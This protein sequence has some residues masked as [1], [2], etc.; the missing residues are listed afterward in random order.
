MDETMDKTLLIN[1][2][3]HHAVNDQTK[4]NQTVK[5]L[6]DGNK[7]TKIQAIEADIIYSSIQKCSVMG[8]PPS[9]DG[10]LTLASF[11]QQLNKVKFQHK[12]HT[13]HTCPILK[14]DFKSMDALQSSLSDVKEYLSSLPARLHKR[15]WINADILAGP[16]EDMNDVEAQ[17]KMQP[18]FDASEFL[19]LVSS[20][21]PKTVLS[22]GFTTSLTDIHAVYT[23]KMV[24]DMIEY[25]KPYSDVTF[26]IR[27]SC[28][29]QSYGV[30]KRLYLADPTWSVTL[31]WSY[32][33][34]KEELDWIY[35]TLE[36]SSLRNRTYYDMMGFHAHLNQK[37]NNF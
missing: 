19:K 14:L 13:I 5:D 22:I 30:L 8:H 27:A 26:P 29:R 35:N 12:Q 3:W 37:Q 34:P 15:V 6:D 7:N 36:N 17:E 10:D 28:F 9:V 24:N 4:L 32:E 33:L 25:A 16:G 1:I 18:K 23:N 11:L 2:N 20:E 21:L 31:W